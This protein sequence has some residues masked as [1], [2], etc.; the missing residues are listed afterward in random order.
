MVALGAELGTAY[1]ELVDP[2]EQRRRLTAHSLLVADGDP[3][4]M[5]IDEDFLPALEFRYT[6]LFPLVKP[7][8]NA[9]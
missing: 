6:V 2:V 8:W 5:Q 7:L 1:S 9:R 4:T 3:E